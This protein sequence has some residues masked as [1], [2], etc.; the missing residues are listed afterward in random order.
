MDEFVV[1]EGVDHEQ[2]EVDP[3]GDVAL[4]DGITDVSAPYRSP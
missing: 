1:G 4:Q 3:S 2:G